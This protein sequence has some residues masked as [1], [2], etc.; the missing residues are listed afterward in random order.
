MTARP[1][2][3][4]H[5]RDS[6]WVDGPART[7]LETA[8]HIDRHRV[9]YHVGVLVGD[10]N[11]NHELATALR[12]RGLPVHAI[13]DRP[14]I[15]RAVI[16]DMVRLMEDLEIDVLHSSEFR[17]NVL[18][19]LAT[20]GRRVK[21]VSTVHGWIANDGKGRAY[22]LIDKALL[23]SFDR[24]IFVSH[25]TRSLVPRLW[26]SDARARVLHNG[27]MLDSYGA[28][29]VNAR[30]PVRDLS[31]GASLVNIGR[32]SPEKGQDLLLRAVAALADDHPEL[33]LTF[34]GVGPSEPDLRA[35]AAQLGI[36]ARV[37]FIGYVSDMPP[38]YARTDLVVQSSLTEGL[39]NV[40]L[41]AAYLRVP[42]VATAVGGTAEVV[43]HGSSAWLI[44]PGSV[45]ALVDG[46]RR[47]LRAPA[48]FAAMGERAHAR[49]REH[50]SFE[51]RTRKLEELYEA[52]PGVRA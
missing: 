8:A 17:S 2:R 41:E 51:A 52:L 10:A 25:K 16:A 26:V 1:I 18:T 14:G 5:L 47:F 4:L 33:R 19:L 43:E 23:R 32:L 20:R 39:P 35:L 44:P 34:A 15:D 30:R 28:D 40:I 9:D 11:G 42:M 24:V 21:R 45:D 6:P 48:D 46:I 36:A 3:V 22:R 27:L 12:A 13:T 49:I 31:R 29:V 37:E 50:F 7:I 38:L